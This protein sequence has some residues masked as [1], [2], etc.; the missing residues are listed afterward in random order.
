[1]KKII[2]KT[3]KRKLSELHPWERNPRQATDKQAQDLSKSLDKFNLADPLIVNT[4]NTII[5][6][7]FRYKI[8]KEKQIEEIDVRMPDRKLTDKEIKELNIRLNK[9]LGS[10]DFDEL[11]NF[12]EDLL[13]NIGFESDELDNIFQLDNEK[14]DEVPELPKKAKSKAGDLFQLGNHRL[15]CADATKKENVEWLMNGEKADMV[16]TDP[17]YGINVIKG[18]I[19][20][21]IG[22]GKIIKAGLYRPIYGDNKYFNPSFLFEYS[23]NLIIFGANNF[24]KSLPNSRGWFC[25]DKLDGLEGTTK[26]FSDI[27]LGWTSFNKPARLFKH[28]WQGLQ[29]GSEHK[30]KRCH[31]TQKPIQLIINLLSY[32][33]KDM[34]LILDLFGGS[35]STLIACEKLN[36]RCFMM[37]IDPLYIDVIISRWEK[38][39]GRKAKKIK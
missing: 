4:D 16:F 21:S 9:N 3:E 19:I 31:P 29:K 32:Y 1:M 2:W 39:T 8:L 7:H 22:G 14:D 17:P 15:L 25:W 24:A 36:R 6:G 27:E 23:K 34:N 11:A 35:G 13:K 37:E 26:N 10:W 18:K 28:R 38:F 12:E 30:E 33:A 5:G 20:G